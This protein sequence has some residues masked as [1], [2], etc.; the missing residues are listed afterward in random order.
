MCKG[1]NLQILQ[2]LADGSMRI[3][4][5]N[6]KELLIRTLTRQADLSG[7]TTATLT[8][9]YVVENM[10]G[11]GYVSV[12]VSSDGGSNWD[13]LAVYLYDDV[14]GSESFDITFYA[15][16]NTQIRFAIGSEKKV[17]MYLSMMQRGKKNLLRMWP[18]IIR[19]HYIMI[20]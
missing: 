9:D 8:Y 7:A 15:S 14:S 2:V 3:G 10:G 18:N 11:D 20:I 17:K 13:T 12:Q 6:A 5:K 4:D 16:S 1:K 19:A